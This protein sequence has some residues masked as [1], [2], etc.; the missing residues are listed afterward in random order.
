M[1]LLIDKGII[2]FT[3]LPESAQNKMLYRQRLRSKMGDKL[4]LLGDD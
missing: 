4:E 3:D 2:L 1:E